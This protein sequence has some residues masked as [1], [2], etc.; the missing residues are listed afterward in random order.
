[1]INF[2]AWTGNQQ[3]MKVDPAAVACHRLRYLILKASIEC[4]PRGS[5]ASF[6]DHCELDRTEVHRA[7]R[8]GRFS[9]KVAQRIEKA[10]GRNVV[11]REWLIY[12]LEVTDLT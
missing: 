3:L 10:C 11:R 7:M 5:V 9:A 8:E 2:P 4:T 12:P 1:M 6:S